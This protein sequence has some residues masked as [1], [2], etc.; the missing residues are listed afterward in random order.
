MGSVLSSIAD[1]VTLNAFDFNRQGG[2]FG[3]IGRDMRGSVGLPL[4]GGDTQAAPTTTTSTT[5]SAESALGAVSGG[6]DQ[7][8]DEKALKKKKLS[9]KKLG[10]NA[11]QIP[12]VAPKAT[13][14]TTGVST[15][16]TQ[17]VQI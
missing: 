1:V 16:A 5:T 14:A 10:A 13:A 11:L 7:T 17:G 3:A 2:G 6:T 9:A 4:G 8:F 12:L 15:T